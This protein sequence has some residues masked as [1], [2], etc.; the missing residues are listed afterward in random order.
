MLFAKVD[1]PDNIMTLTWGSS[2]DATDFDTIDVR[3]CFT[4]VSA[5]G[6]K[7]RKPKDKIK[8]HLKNHCPVKIYNGAWDTNTATWTPNEATPGAAYQLEA[9]AKN[10]AGDYVAYSGNAAD[11]P[12]KSLKVV[13][14]DA[15]T[16]SLRAAAAICSCVGPIIIIAY[17]IYDNAGKQD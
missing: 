1:S 14:V 16:G 10:A 13:P 11:P 3:G 7:W 4:T 5:A 6:R 12:T 8:F 17:F 2:Y 15:V 9:F